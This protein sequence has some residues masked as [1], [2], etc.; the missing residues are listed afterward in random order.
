VQNGLTNETVTLTGNAKV[1]NAQGWLTGEP[2]VW[3]RAN[4][5]LHAENQKMIFRQNIGDVMANTNAPAVKTNFPPRTAD[6]P[7]TKTN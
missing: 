6:L 2:I 1:E 5:S 7:M 3:D 4:N